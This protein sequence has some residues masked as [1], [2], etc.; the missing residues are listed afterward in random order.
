MGGPE[1]GILN[2]NLPDKTNIFR[3]LFDSQKFCWEGERNCL[4]P[5]ATTPLYLDVSQGQVNENSAKMPCPNPPSHAALYT[6][7]Q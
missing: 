2:K 6:L 1:F 5:P 4:L 3:L 7:G